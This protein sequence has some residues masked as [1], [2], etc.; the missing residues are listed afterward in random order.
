M[1]R[2][3][4][5]RQAAHH[6]VRRRA[7]GGGRG[8][9]GRSAA[10]T[11][12]PTRTTLTGLQAD[13][14]YHVRIR[15]RNDEGVSAWSDP[16]AGS[17][18]AAPVSPPPTPPDGPRPPDGPTTPGV[19]TPPD[20]PGAPDV[21]ETTSP[22]SG[23]AGP[24]S[25]QADSAGAGAGSTAPARGGGGE[26]PAGNAPPSAAG[27]GG[28]PGTASTAARGSATSRPGL[29]PPAAATTMTRAATV[30]VTGLAALFPFLVP[31]VPAR[32]KRKERPE[33]WP[34]PESGVPVS[35]PAASLFRVRAAGARK[36]GAACRRCRLSRHRRCPHL[37]SVRRE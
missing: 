3:R 23:A 10:S 30:G 28:E 34:S 22:E 32:R 26:G 6:L 4:H 16:G 17:T 13:T 33:A 37:P 5:D 8:A 27:A 36:R 21:P 20:G 11:A 14:A 15:A 19:T 35:A 9:G 12:R 18:S 1:G 24:A 7:Q 31:P 25:P 29:A 2:A